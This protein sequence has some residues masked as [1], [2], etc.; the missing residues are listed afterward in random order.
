VSQD[1]EHAVGIT[2]AAQPPDVG[3]QEL[4]VFLEPGQLLIGQERQIP[5]AALGPR[6]RAALWALRVFVIA[7]SAM[8]VYA[9]FAQLY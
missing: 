6:A 3:V 2:T 1:T 7:V 5:R 9:F 4:A 8:V